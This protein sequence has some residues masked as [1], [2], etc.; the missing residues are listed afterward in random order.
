MSKARVIVE[1][2]SLITAPQPM[3]PTSQSNSKKAFTLIELLVVIAII[4]ILASLLL[5]ALARAKMQA[6]QVSCMNNEKQLGIAFQMYAA[7]N[8]DSM[9]YPNWGVNNNGW[10]YSVTGNVPAGPPAPNTIITL[11]QYQG[12]GLWQYTGTPNAN[13]R[14]VY[15]CPVDVNFTNSLIVPPNYSDAGLNAFASRGMQ[16]STYTMNGA[17]MGFKSQPPAVGSPPQGR[18]HRLS[19]ILPA[20]SYCLWEP[21]VLDPVNSYNDGANEPSSDQGP[22]PLHGGSFPKNPKGCN[23]LGF[24]GHVQYL[25]GQIA[26]NLYLNTPGVLWCDPDS[27]SGTGDAG[28]PAGGGPITTSSQCKLWP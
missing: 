4:A 23:V 21:N 14:P 25:L 16:M 22:F 11:Q 20:T 6:Q 2:I 9:V 1:K 3:Q 28:E 10:L 8:K 19:T 12:G 15:W 24:D 13:H 27:G 7:D 26:T 5:P 17:I 18:T